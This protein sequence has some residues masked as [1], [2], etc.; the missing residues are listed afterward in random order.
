MGHI[1]SSTIK[2]PSIHWNQWVTQYS[3][4][5]PVDGLV[6]H[7]WLHSHS[8]GSHYQTIWSW[9]L[10]MVISHQ[11]SKMPYQPPNHTSLELCFL[12]LNKD[13]V[14]MGISSIA[15]YYLSFFMRRYLLRSC[16][17]FIDPT[18]G[19]KHV[20]FMAI[21]WTDDSARSSHNGFRG[22]WV[23]YDNEIGADNLQSF[24]GH[25]EQ[26]TA[27]W[28]D[29]WFP[30][31]M[32]PSSWLCLDSHVTAWHLDVRHGCVE[33]SGADR[34][35]STGKSRVDSDIRICSIWNKKNLVS[36]RDV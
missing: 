4:E 10:G 21:E 7:F 35:T 32:H 22:N 11:I 14:S 28:G 36:K 26:S 17:F 9:T 25:F 16:T 12:I 23:H 20:S 29:L 19:P 3:T 30:A 1:Y 5:A 33:F 34:N 27:C 18:K 31:M 15:L 8:S 2:D 24:L 6:S 13:N